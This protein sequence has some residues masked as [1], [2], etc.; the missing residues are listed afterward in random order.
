V[1]RDALVE[2]GYSLVEAEHALASIDEDLPAAERVRLALRS[3][4]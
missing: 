3:A 2:L 4:A 1:A